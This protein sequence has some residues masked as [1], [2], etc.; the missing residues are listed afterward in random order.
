MFSHKS[1]TC[2]LCD[3]LA[4]HICVSQHKVMFG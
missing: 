2:I 4:P 3:T 1:K